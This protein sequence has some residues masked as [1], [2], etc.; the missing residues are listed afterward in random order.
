MWKQLQQRWGLHSYWQVFLVLLVFALTGTSSMYVTRFFMQVIGLGADSD[1]S[2]W[3]KITTK[4]IITLIVYQFLL[5]WIGYLFGQF[6]F[7]WRFELKMWNR[8]KSLFSRKDETITRK[9]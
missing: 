5:L 7:F 9:N 2:T 8:I 6:E 3:I 1:A 4:A